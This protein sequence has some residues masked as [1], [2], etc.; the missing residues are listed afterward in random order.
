M[1]KTDLDTPS[2][3]I[4]SGTLRHNIEWMQKVADRFGVR[5]RPH[6]KTHKS[7]HI[8]RRQ[9][10]A[11]ACGITVAKL[12]EAE[13]MTDGG[14]EDILI[15]NQ[16]I[17]SAKI[18]RA[19]ELARRVRLAVLVDSQA[20]VEML[21]RAASV[22]GQILD[23]LIE[24]DTGKGRCGLV[25]DEEIV[26]LAGRVADASHLRL[27]GV[28]THE[29]HVPRGA[30]G[31]GE[32]QERAVAAGARIV[33]VAEILRGQGHPVE[34]V[35]VGSTPAAPYTASVEG[36]TE[37]RPGTYV[38][39]DVNQMALG[40][41]HP[42]ECA[43]SVLATVISRPAPDRAVLDAGSKSLFAEAARS[44]FALEGYGGFGYIREAS[45]ARI[46]SLSEEHAVVNLAAGV[47]FPDIGDKVTIIPN[48]VCPAVNLHD[49][50]HIVDGEDVI[51]TWPIAAR[52][53]I[54]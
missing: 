33:E 38:F 53:A 34:E 30:G 47:D 2:L 24:V 26:A 10:E 16:I 48:H 1:R 37:M 14:L 7:P 19:L 18:A 41:A 29:G 25:N 50:L 15:A 6:V 28:E 13:V 45:G 35:S 3:I 43:L 52:G 40:Q 27:R 20:G 32:L 42:E 12:D 8:A 51:E 54:R 9:M 11:G 44:G 49:E 4:D 5:L 17:G 39:N 21:E 36:I 46:V 31:P 22:T 23:V